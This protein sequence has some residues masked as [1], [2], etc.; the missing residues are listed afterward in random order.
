MIGKLWLISF[1]VNF[2][3]SAYCNCCAQG[4]CVQVREIAWT[5]LWYDDQGK[6]PVTTWEVIMM[7]EDNL[8]EGTSK[9]V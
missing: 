4:T 1:C 3:F 2:E 9:G 8:P 5:L 6:I 7:V